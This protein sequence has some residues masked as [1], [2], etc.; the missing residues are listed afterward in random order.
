[1]YR[2]CGSTA[3]TFRSSDR[4][5]CAGRRSLCCGA[6]QCV[7]RWRD[8]CSQFDQSGGGEAKHEGDEAKKICPNIQLVTVRTRKLISRDIGKPEVRYFEFAENLEEPSVRGLAGEAYLDITEAATAMLKNEEGEALSHNLTENAKAFVVGIDG[9]NDD[10]GSRTFAEA[11][12]AMRP[13]IRPLRRG[14]AQVA[15]EATVKRDRL[16]PF[17]RSQPN[18]MLAKLISGTHK[19]ISR[20]FYPRTRCSRFVDCRSAA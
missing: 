18:K 2:P 12:Q 16:Y 8:H 4:G 13:R 14:A 7:E 19:P 5:V 9:D 1:M 3:S 6:V 20:L 17:G 15:R 10:I 11:L